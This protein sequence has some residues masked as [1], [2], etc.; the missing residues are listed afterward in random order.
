MAKKNFLLL[1]MED[2]KIKKIS[3][4]I[5]NESCRKLLDFLSEKEAT[6]SELAEKLSIP[7]STVHYNLQQLVDAGLVSADEFHYSK[8]G[9]EISHYKLANKYIIIAPKKTLG[10][11]EKLKNIFPVVLVVSGAALVIQY[12]SKP[13]VIVPQVQPMVAKSFESSIAAAPMMAGTA[14]NVSSSTPV[15]LQNIALWFFVGAVFALIAYLIIN[16][17]RKK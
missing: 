3:N 15:L 1:S 9:K 5:S 6:E 12:L 4:V 16:S 11:K 13:S 8:K 10:L 17:L 7:I 14:Q 2:S